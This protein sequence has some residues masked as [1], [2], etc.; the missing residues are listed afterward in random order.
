MFVDKLCKIPTFDLTQNKIVRKRCFNDADI[1]VAP[2]ASFNTL[3][4][5][6]ILFN[7]TDYVISYITELYY[8]SWIQPLDRLLS[9]IHFN[10]PI[11]LIESLLED[12]APYLQGYNI[13]Y[14]G[15]ITL[16]DKSNIDFLMNY[17]KYH[18]TVS[19]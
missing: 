19:E 1:C 11:D 2:K 13:I 15:V 18:H 16:A 8:A 14:E 3:Y 6:V 10:K 4:D 7:G 12:N 9:N 17:D 5:A